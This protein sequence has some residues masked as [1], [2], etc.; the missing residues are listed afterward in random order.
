MYLYSTFVR[1]RACVARQRIE[2]FPY[3]IHGA[4]RPKIENSHSF[5]NSW[6]QDSSIEGP[7]S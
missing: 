4:L 5:T 6:N 1:I 2:F 7:K 3:C